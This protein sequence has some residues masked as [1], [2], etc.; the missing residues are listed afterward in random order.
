MFRKIG[1]LSGGER[2]RI[3][4]ADLMMKKINVLV[5][6]EPTNHLDID[7][8]EVLE[9][10]VNQFSGT[11]LAVSHDRYFLTNCFNEIYWLQ[12]GHLNK[13]RHFSQFDH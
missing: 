6:D 1:T 11:V 13:E 5:L 9:E 4:L 2:V 10:A 3:R 12:N 7:S 8:R